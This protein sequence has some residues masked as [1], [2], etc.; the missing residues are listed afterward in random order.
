MI[1]VVA[2]LTVI[3]AAPGSDLVRTFSWDAEGMPSPEQGVERLPPGPSMPFAA[4]SVENTGSQPLTRRVLRIERPGIDRQAYALRGSVRADG[5]LGK[6]CIEMWSVF[7]DGRYFSRTI[8]EEGP[9]R[10]LEGTFS[11]RE[12]I[13]PFFSRPGAPPPAALE[14][15]VVLPSRGRVTL[16]PLT[17]E[18]FDPGGAAPAGG[19]EWPSGAKIGV[20]FGIIGSLLGL[21]GGTMGLLMT[22]GRGRRLVLGS[23]L[24]W[25][26]LGLIAIVASF[27]PPL[28]GELR[29]PLL[30]V[31]IVCLLLG[32][33]L[34]MP[35][36]RRFE[37]IELRKMKAM[38]TQR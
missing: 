19:S 37:A 24:A 29:P 34:Y 30:N 28:S 16:G 25:A 20:A 22:L 3:A 1:T 15:N 7:P 27:I 10:H 8:S 21:W 11:W 4:I 35:A 26:V 5:V 38:D 32:T 13:L 6:A 23:L 36:R 17:L 2:L 33:L 31:G 9:M 18:Q 12:F 14:I